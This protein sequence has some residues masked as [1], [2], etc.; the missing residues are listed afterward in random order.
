M[1]EYRAAVVAGDPNAVSV[2][3]ILTKANVTIPLHPVSSKACPPRTTQSIATLLRMIECYSEKQIV[4]ALTII[5]EAYGLKTGVLR[6]SLIKTMAEWIKRH[7]DTDRNT[8]I[9]TLQGIDLDQLEKD[10]RS[11][12]AIEKRTMPDAFMLVLEKKYDAARKN[13]GVPAEGG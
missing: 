12:R 1:N 9:V 4:W 8:M 3:N 10:A 5:P 7:P 6:A 2:A 13:G 11:Y